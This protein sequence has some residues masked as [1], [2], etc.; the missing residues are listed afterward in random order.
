RLIE[1]ALAALER[2]RPGVRELYFVGFAPDSRQ[3]VFLREVRFVK[4][5]F[6][7]RFGAAGRSIVLANSDTALEEF[8]I[9]SATNLARALTRV[10]EA[11]NADEDI[12][13]LFLT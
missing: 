10:G 12:L 11:M 7:E 3:D 5:L 1:R 2:G 13:F 4:R 8:P 9:A 6:E